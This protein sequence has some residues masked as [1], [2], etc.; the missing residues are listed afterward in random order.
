M[1][2]D[3]VNLETYFPELDGFKHKEI[4]NGIEWPWEV[5]TR[6][7]SYLE[8]YI[9]LHRKTLPEIMPRGVE[10]ML[11]SMR[12]EEVILN[13]TGLV[14]IERDCIIAGTDILLEEG[15]ILEPGAMIKAP[16][17]IGKDSEVRQG[18]YMRGNSLVGERC[19]I[20]HTTEFKNSIFMN[21]SEAGHFAYV[22]DSVVGSYVNLGAGTKLANLQLRRATAKRE[23]TF[24][25]IYLK[26]DGEKINTGTAKIGA[27]MGDFSEAGCNCVTAPGV[28][29]GAHSWAFANKTVIKG[30]Y[31][32]H[33]VVK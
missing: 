14:E 31:S 4:F 7:G 6:I 24:P 27:F 9:E 10:L 25:P 16:A 26:I 5:L 33:T 20:G 18:A 30:Y 22:G 3:F 1:K 2:E 23:E 28:F 17:V 32:P 12:F 13:V 11:R 19:T 21:H 29:F 8:K 15:V